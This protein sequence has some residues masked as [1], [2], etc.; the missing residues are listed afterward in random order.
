MSDARKA[1]AEAG[2][3]EDLRHRLD[4]LDFMAGWNKH[5]PSLWKEP[6]TA[7]KPMIWHWADAKAGLDAAGRLINAE[8]A[9]RRNLFMVNPVEGNH[10]ATLRTLVSAYQMILPGETA[11]THRHS[12]NALRLVLDVE[13]NCY[14]VVDGVRIDMKP[15]D[16]LL[17]PGMCWHGHGNEGARPGYWI[18]FLDVPLVHLL[19]P[20]FLDLWEGL[21]PVE[22]Q[23]RDSNFVFPIAQTS[24]ALAEAAPDGYGRVRIY[25][26]APS[27]PT[28]DLIMERLKA[29]QHGRPLRS[30]ENQI[31]AVVSGAGTSRIGDASF[32]WSRGDVFVAPSWHYVSHKASEDAVLFCVSDAPVHEKLGFLR[33]EAAEIM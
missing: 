21:Q 28:T 30:T 14:T 1:L 27:M 8:Q 23:T 16:V 11:R 25:L 15:G 26:D 19:E 32:R 18:D 3:L 33:V 29:D 4:P 5:E 31:F 22:K 10:Y 17:T 7:Y 6:R 12:P 13:E 9:E 2:N 20:M 24:K